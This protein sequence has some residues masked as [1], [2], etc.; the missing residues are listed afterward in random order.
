ME[1]ERFAA[2]I[3]ALNGVREYRF[4]LN[5]SKKNAG[6]DLVLDSSFAS[7]D[8]IRAYVGAPLHDALA[9]FMDTFVEQTVVA[10]Y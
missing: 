8:D 10:D 7:N 3:K 2:E 6:F 5:Q 1:L 4:A 9:K